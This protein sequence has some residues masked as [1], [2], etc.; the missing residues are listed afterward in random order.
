VP[1]RSLE[2][3][4][5]AAALIKDSHESEFDKSTDEQPTITNNSKSKD[6]ATGSPKINEDTAD[7]TLEEIEQLTNEPLVHAPDVE[8]IAYTT[9][10]GSNGV[11]VRVKTEEAAPTQPCEGF[12][13]SRDVIMIC[14]W[15]IHGIFCCCS[16]KNVVTQLMP[17]HA[18]VSNLN[19]PCVLPIR[20]TKSDEI[21]QEEHDKF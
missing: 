4:E 7:Y 21:K 10:K 5:R 2:K 3:R 1:A 13:R 14:G 6:P 15:A 9:M 16:G 11:A 19:V 20:T 12:H 18:M 8:G 17:R